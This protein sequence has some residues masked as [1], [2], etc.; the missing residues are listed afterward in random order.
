MKR[1]LTFLTLAGA[2]AAAALWA[3]GC[4]PRTP[5]SPAATRETAPA[6]SEKPAGEAA[7]EEKAAYACPMHPEITSD[8]PGKCSICGMNLEPTTK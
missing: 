1:M 5:T 2:L 6:T 8:K 7:K 4:G 3:S